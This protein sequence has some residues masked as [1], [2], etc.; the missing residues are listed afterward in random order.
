MRLGD[1]RLSIG[2]VKAYAAEG[3]RF[4]LTGGANQALDTANADAML[5]GKV[6]LLDPGGE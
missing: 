2:Y 1:G 3:I 6:L 5:E 4:R